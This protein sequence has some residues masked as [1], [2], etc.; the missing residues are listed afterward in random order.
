MKKNNLPA[1]DK[2]EL[3]NIF[4]GLCTCYTSEKLLAE[5]A[6]NATHCKQ[7]CCDDNRAMGYSYSDYLKDIP[8]RDGGCPNSP[9]Y[10]NWMSFLRKNR[11]KMI[12]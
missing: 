7:K 5:N 9:L 12:K 1:L 11:Y 4:G 10:L 8:S 6:V 3:S 2:R